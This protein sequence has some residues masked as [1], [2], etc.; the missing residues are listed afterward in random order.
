MDRYKFQLGEMVFF[1]RSSEKGDYGYGRIVQ[2]DTVV[3][4]YCP[5]TIGNFYKMD[6]YW[7]LV[8]EENIFRS[9]TTVVDEFLAQTDA[10]IE[11]Y[12]EREAKKDG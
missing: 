6:S 8:H 4:R 9:P 11:E 7:D 3:N 12:E 1:H 10:L 2:V 5:R